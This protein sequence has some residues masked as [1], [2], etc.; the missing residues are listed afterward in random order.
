MH[1]ARRRVGRVDNQ[2]RRATGLSVGDTIR[3]RQS[4]IG[5]WKLVED[6]QLVGGYTIRCLMK[7]MPARQRNAMLAALP[8]LVGDEPISR[9]V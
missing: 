6:G 8:F 7:R 9:A 3:V 5:D 1:F 2:P 4:D